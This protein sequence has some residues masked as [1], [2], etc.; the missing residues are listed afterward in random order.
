[1]REYGRKKPV[2]AGFESRK[3]IA[4]VTKRQLS[5]I[6]TLIQKLK[7]DIFEEED[8]D[9][10]MV[11]EH[12]TSPFYT[13]IYHDV[14]VEKLNLGTPTIHNVIFAILNKEFKNYED[15]ILNKFIKL[16]GSNTKIIAEYV[17]AVNNKVP[18]NIKDKLK[19]YFTAD[20]TGLL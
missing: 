7:F 3:V 6:N 13:K 9:I 8:F 2:K 15:K 11:W 12:L 18:L 1:M 14:D 19:W 4:E 20:S 5:D 10:Y 17:D 16:M